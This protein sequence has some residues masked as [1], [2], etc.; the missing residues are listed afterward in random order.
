MQT[1]NFCVF[2]CLW[3][4]VFEFSRVE[5]DGTCLSQV[6]GLS[7]PPPRKG[8]EAQMFRS[9]FCN[10][11]CSPSFSWIFLCRPW[12]S[13]G[14]FLLPF[15][16]LGFLGFPMSSVCFPVC[17]LR[18]LCFLRFPP[19]PTPH[20]REGANPWGRGGRG[21]RDRHHVCSMEGFQ[22]FLW[23]QSELEIKKSWNPNLARIV[24]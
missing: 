1:T 2:R 22:G 3:S 23:I 18:F 8:L 4:A 15:F 10:F 5:F 19:H 6:S 24:G 11:G 7:S 9:V 16:F 14:C 21:S 20:H 17:L 13:V 12:F